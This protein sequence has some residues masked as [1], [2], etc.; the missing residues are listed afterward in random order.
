MKRR[1][2]TIVELL[3]VIAIIG[4]LVSLLLPAVQYAR[5]SAR[6]ASCVNN[7][8]QCGTAMIGYASAKGQLPP[9]RRYDSKT[10]AV[11]N[12]PVWILPELDQRGMRDLIRDGSL[13]PPT[14]I[15]V[16]RCP[17][18]VRDGDQYPLSYAANGGR[19]NAL[20]A[21]CNFDWLENGLFC[22][23]SHDNNPAFTFPFP[24]PTGHQM[25]NLEVR[26]RIERVASR[27]GTSST[28]MLAE[29]AAIGSWLR[30]NSEQEACVL[31][32]ADGPAAFGLNVNHQ[33]TPAELAA[34][35]RLARP[36]SCHPGGFHVV[37]CDGS[38]HLIAESIE[39][40]IFAVLMSQRG[41]RANDPTAGPLANS[42]NANPVW[43]SP[44]IW[45]GSPPRRIPNETP[46]DNYPGATF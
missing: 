25:R 24:L 4:V 18:A 1:A 5:E 9:A 39:Y 20:A 2:F 35:P 27:D 29:N 16:L 43:Q 7:L 33:A 38:V 12:W 37:M 42:A 45:G 14:L 17:S 30:A 41:E 13:P 6:R 19:L 40:R 3:V 36:S 28:I 15:P 23:L 10:G 32:F 31:W 21:D 8:R 22:D 26:S 11:L 46:P 34:E 44:W